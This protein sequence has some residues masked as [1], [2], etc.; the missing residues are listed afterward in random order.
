MIAE[1]RAESTLSPHLAKRGRPLLAGGLLLLVLGLATAPARAQWTYWRGESHDGVASAKG[2]ISSWSPEGENLIWTQ[3]FIGR[4]TPVIVDGRVC[5]IG[6][7]GEGIDR[8]ERVA[9]F[10]AGDGRMLWEHRFNVY[11]TTVPHNRVGWAS[12]AADAETGTV[13]AH[14]VAGQLIAYAPDGEILWRHS[15]AEDYGRLSGYGGRTQ[16][17]LV[18]GDRVILSY[19]STAWGKHTPLRHRYYAFDKRSGEL[20]WISTPG[21]MA[22]DFNTQS[23]PVITE[24]N[25]QR[26]LVAGN[27]DGRVYAMKAGSGEK[28]WEFHLS[29][30]GLNSTVLARDGVV[31]AAHSEENVDDPTMGR[32]VAIRAD[33]SGDVTGTHEL[34]RINE[35]TAGFP[36]P[37]FHDGRLFLV[38]NSA[39][40]HSIDAATGEIRWDHSIGTV[41]KG[42]PVFA[43]G[44]IYVT[45]TNGRFHIL[46]P[47][48]DGVESLDVDE[49]KAEGDRYAEIYGSVAVGYGRVYFATEGG[50]YCLGDPTK[51]FKL[52]KSKPGASKPEP[53]KG[54]ATVAH[55]VPAEVMIRPGEKIEFALRSFDAQGRPLGETKAKWSLEGLSGKIDGKGRYSAGNDGGFHAGTVKAEAAG[56]S[57]SAG[58]RIMPDLPWSWDFEDLDEGQSPPQWIGAARKYVARDVDGNTVLVKA[59]RERGLNRTFLF[60]GASWLNNYTIE[61]EVMGVKQGRRVPDIGLIAGGYILDMQGAHQNLQIRSWS[62]ELRMAKDQEFPWEFGAWYRIKLRVETDEKRALVRGKVWPR[63]EPEPDAWT[64]EAEDPLPIAGGSP[65]LLGYSPTELF[66]DNVKVTKNQ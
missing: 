22:K 13:Y 16:T 44:K 27:A 9:C 2:L 37:T 58:V 4:S 26:L 32:V 24:V 7:I 29:K 3:E 45:E 62:S 23:V 18:D 64:I 10:D 60:M 34:W 38:D 56:L 40:L 12:L 46:R 30:R 42:S 15:L 50:I 19:V 11:L 17:P 1:S 61:A 54:P 55:V 28:V 52:P 57:A 20:L 48:D 31:Y 39:N 66:Y 59:P 53:G 5:A 51:K 36:S 41:G 21:Q 6:R 63:D 43:D 25:G 14:G 33:G 49:L 65:G 8:Q 35:M 47:G